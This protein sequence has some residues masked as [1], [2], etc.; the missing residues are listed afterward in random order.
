MVGPVLRAARKT[1]FYLLSISK[2]LKILNRYSGACQF[3][4]LTPFLQEIIQK[5]AKI[6]RMARNRVGFVRVAKSIA[7]TIQA[8]YTHTIKMEIEGMLGRRT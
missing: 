8:Y 2:A 4:R 3:I 6:S 1:K 7:Q 5:M